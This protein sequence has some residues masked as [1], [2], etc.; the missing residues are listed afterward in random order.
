MEV[1][2]IF[3]QLYFQ[4]VKQTAY[5]HVNVACHRAHARKLHRRHNKSERT[6]EQGMDKDWRQNDKLRETKE[7]PKGDSHADL[8]FM[9]G[10]LSA[11]PNTIV[12][13]QKFKPIFFFFSFSKINW[14]LLCLCFQ[15]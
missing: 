5:C 13:P 12:M 10:L 9:L 1:I 14:L 11:V 7:F 2:A 3:E 4:P 6:S 15:I 8:T